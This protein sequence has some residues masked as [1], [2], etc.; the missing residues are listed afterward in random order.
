M[1]PSLLIRGNEIFVTIYKNVVVIRKIICKF[2]NIKQKFKLGRILGYVQ[3][4]L[5]IRLLYVP[6][7][8][9]KMLVNRVPAGCINTE[10]RSVHQQVFTPIQSDHGNHIYEM[11]VE[12]IFLSFRTH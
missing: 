7:Q 10:L 9:S 2:K 8:T 3:L 6:T 1:N 4:T 12:I 5:V 11:V